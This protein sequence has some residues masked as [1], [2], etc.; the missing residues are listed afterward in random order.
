MSEP[1]NEYTPSVIIADDAPDVCMV[2]QKSL[3]K[4]NC[5][6]LATAN[7]GDDAIEQLEKYKPDIIFL[8]IEMPNKNGFEV[9]DII[10]EKNIPVC[11]IM[12]SAHSSKENLIKSVKKGAL[13]FI[14]KPH[15]QDKIEKVIQSYRKSRKK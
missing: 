8:D 1:E 15:S 6:V 4:C 10:K 3:E 9:L 14:V 2:L 12:L 13:G 5:Q 11:S 7:N